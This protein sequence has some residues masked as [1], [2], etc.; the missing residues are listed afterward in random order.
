MPVLVESLRNV[1][2]LSGGESVD[3]HKEEGEVLQ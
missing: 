1:T 2:T 3:M